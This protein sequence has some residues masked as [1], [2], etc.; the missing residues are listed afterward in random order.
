MWTNRT[1]R[2]LSTW[3]W[4]QFMCACVCVCVLKLF[5]IDRYNLKNGLDRTMCIIVFFNLYIF[6]RYWSLKKNDIKKTK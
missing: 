1:G 3:K 2:K 5:P 4:K 6:I